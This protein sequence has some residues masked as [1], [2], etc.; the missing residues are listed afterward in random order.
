MGADSGFSSPGRQSLSLPVFNKKN[1]A[2]SD[3]N[4]GSTTF[5]FGF[6]AFI[7]MPTPVIP[8]VIAPMAATLTRTL[9]VRQSSSALLWIAISRPRAG[10]VWWAQRATAAKAESLPRKNHAFLNTKAGAQVPSLILSD[11]S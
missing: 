1:G 2:R 10:R 6:P 9:S 7:L 8:V 5:L 4:N 11:P 3:A